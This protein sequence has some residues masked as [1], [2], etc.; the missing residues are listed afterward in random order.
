M[1]LS[2]EEAMRRAAHGAMLAGTGAAVAVSGPAFGQEGEKPAEKSVE[3]DKVQVTGSRIRRVDTET[4]SPVFVI[5]RATIEAA[6]VTTLG[7]LVQELPS[8][9]GAATNPR[10]NNGGGTGAAVVSLR[11]L[12]EQRTL[13]L[14]NGRRLTAVTN[15]IAEGV[16]IN[17]IPINLIERVE[18]LKEGASAIYGSDAIGGVVNFITRKGYTGLEMSYD[19]GIT[20]EEDGQRHGVGLTWGF[21]TDKGHM[22]MGLNYNDQDGISAGDRGFSTNALYLYG[23]VVTA[24]GSSRTPTGRFF[25]PDDLATQFG[26]TS[27]T[28]DAAAVGDSLDDYR[29]FTGGDL[30][31][32]QPFNLVLTPQERVGLFT[33]SNYQIAD[34][35]EGYVELFYNNTKS[36][37]AIAPLPFDTRPDDVVISADNIYNPFGTSFGG[38]DAVNPNATFR[39]EALGNRRSE[40]ETN[41][42][43]INIGIRGD[44][45]MI[46]TWRYDA[47]YSLGRTEES[48]DTFGYLFAPGISDALGPSFLADDGTPTCGTPDAPIS[49]CTPLNIFNL[50]LAL[51]DPAQA[52]Q[53]AAANAGY[54]INR[55]RDLQVVNLNFNG[56]L[57]QMPAGAAQLAVG[58]E[59]R[60][61]RLSNDVDFVAQGT[62]PDFLT[63]QLAQETCTNATQGDLKA[64]EFYGELFL[65]LLSGK[66][67]AE[68]L[69]LILGTRYSDYSRFGNT[70]NSKAAIE[71]R[72]VSE[73]LVRASFAE[74]FRAPT[75]TDL[76]LGITA[77]ASTFTDPCTGLTQAALDAADF[78]EL[79]CQNVTP[80]GGFIPDNGQVTGRYKGNDEL[81][82]EEGEVLTYGFVY[83]PNFIKGLSI[84]VDI[85]D[86]ELDDTIE[87][88]DTN[89]TASLCQATGDAT[90]CGLINRF[91]DN[92]QVNFIDQPIVNLGSIDTSGVDVGFKYRVPT[93]RFGKIRLGLDTTY[94]DEFKRTVLGQEIQAAGTYDRQDGNF[95][96][97]RG[98][99]SVNWDIAN[100]ETL[101][102]WRYI[103]GIKVKD[104]DGNP[105]DT[106]GDGVLEQTTLD[107]GSHSY[108]NASVQ[109]TLPAFKAKPEYRT[110]ILF[111]V[112]NVT[113][114]KPP[115]LFQNNVTN[116]NTDVETYDTI[117]RF[118]YA[119]ITQNF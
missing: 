106:D 103:H 23:G 114:K 12:N 14:L 109:Y 60:D 25:L 91:E 18:V 85:W 118:F 42:G 19:Y 73:L 33:V 111:G 27:V 82:P 86:Y 67:Y 7:D 68:A 44:L 84:T 4:A 88:L 64:R 96:R 47:S 110:R 69:N 97:W 52:A 45:P 56:T 58:F 37:F 71:F 105:P 15:G 8:I 5:D 17:A 77:N 107:I 72:P 13:V 11:G 108:V 1:T 104:A 115:I 48:T 119:R 70:T 20:D 55:T 65:P 74:V 95:A 49:G 10:V 41:N 2:I 57:F 98:L 54:G 30:Y 66:P 75:I 93:A 90:F 6:G 61:Q 76:F 34:K 24:G 32:Y 100:F 46:E 116:A 83:D 80:D 36:G 94:T 92:G 117:G 101:L 40:S 21:N 35:V 78:L 29:C 99:G 31:N 38:A 113:D 81:D 50:P 62:A 39:L 102:T 87:P 9:S 43:Q 26:C 79:V 22:M 112:D 53:F 16:D 51:T 63:C 59:Y 28:R 89:T 3:L